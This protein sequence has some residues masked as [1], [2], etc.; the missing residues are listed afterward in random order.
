MFFAVRFYIE[1]V[2]TS[3]EECN[4]LE[5]LLFF[6]RYF[7]VWRGFVNQLVSFCSSIYI[8]D[9][10]KLPWRMQRICGP[11]FCF[12]DHHYKS[13]CLSRDSLSCATP[14][15]DLCIILKFMFLYLWYTFRT[16]LVLFTHFVY[17]NFFICICI[18]PCRIFFL[19]LMMPLIG[20]SS[21]FN[22][23]FQF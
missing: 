2:L 8:E 16:I 14:S 5:D 19:S 18:L 20:E 22:F 10:P 11:C 6:T 12:K 15:F 4:A 9:S 1:P 23:N 21:E 3:R 7:C 13:F 17:T